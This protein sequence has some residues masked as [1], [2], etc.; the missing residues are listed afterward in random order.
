[1]GEPFF[2]MHKN[3]QV[4]LLSIDES[5]NAKLERK[6]PGNESHFPIGAQLNNSK[7]AEWWKNRYIPDN[8]DGLQRALQNANYP[9]TGIA[10]VDN[11]ALSLN[12]CYWIK[13]RGS[14]LTWE[15]VSLFS[16][17]FDDRIGESLFH[18]KKKIKMKKNRFDVGSS[19]GELKK[20][21]IIEEDG[22]RWLVKGNLGMSFQ[23]SLNEVFISRIHQTLNPKYALRY[24]LKKMDS[25]GR[26]IV[27]C[28]SPNFS[29][30]CAEFVS[31]LEIVDSKKLK[32]SDNVFLL[33]KQGCLELGMQEKEFH[34]YMDYLI[35]TDFLFSNTDRH[36]RNIGILRNPDTLRIIGFSPI[37]D[38][39]NSM[40]YDKTYSDL[41]S[42]DIRKIKTNSFYNSETKMLKCV[43]DFHVL[44]IDEIQPDFGIYQNDTEENQIRYDLIRKKFFEKLEILKGLQQKH[45]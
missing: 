21:W 45:S 4:A 32:G 17:D 33:F 37:F 7:F 28:L 22:S 11:L 5:G 24:D 6:I 8:R 38:N 43:K 1:M 14:D 31:A 41:K 2:L 20:E 27:C 25:D 12:D 34:R 19:S 44:K 42:L 39:G 29:N 30:D 9:S 10:L 3:I 23:Q 26:K 36:L 18:S 16:N 13:P 15:K 40:F 35:L